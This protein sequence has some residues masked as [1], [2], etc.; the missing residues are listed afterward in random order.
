M[1]KIWISFLTIVI[2]ALAQYLPVFIIKLTSFQIK[3][4]T[5]LLHVAIYI[6]VILFIIAAIIIILLQKVIKNPTKLESDYKEPKRY[7]VQY[8]LLG[9]IVVMIYQMFAGLINTW[10]FGELK[11]SPNTERLMD[12]ARQAPIFIILISI[13]GPILEE[14]VFRK[15]I[16]GEIL[17]RLK[18]NIVMRFLI[19]SVVS[20]LLFALAHNDITFIIVYFGM[21]MI[22]S[23]AYVLTKRIA[24]SI[25]IH[26]MQNGFVVIMQVCFGDVLKHLQ[27]QA[28]AIFHL[29]F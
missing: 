27:T 23:L 25:M 10:I 1:S 16:F 9:F 5:Q 18:G 19:A 14:Y 2:Y 6:Q 12:I 22:F 21:G 4:P 17:D 24:V 29:F 20:S 28:N 3:S 7:L 15:V 13:V 11:A 8:A 26:M